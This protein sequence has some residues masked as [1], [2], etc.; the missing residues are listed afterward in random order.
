MPF[1]LM[2][3]LT[4]VFIQHLQINDKYLYHVMFHFLNAYYDALNKNGASQKGRCDKRSLQAARNSL[5]N[6]L[7]KLDKCL[8]DSPI[9]EALNFEI[10]LH[11]IFSQQGNEFHNKFKSNKEKYELCIAFTM[12]LIKSIDNIT[13]ASANNRML[14]P[15]MRRDGE[16]KRFLVRMLARY[17][18]TFDKNYEEAITH[19]ADNPPHG[20]VFGGAFAN[21]V[22]AVFQELPEQCPSG[23]IMKN[24]LDKVFKS[25]S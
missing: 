6:S 9:R 10:A 11:E 14:T 4:P 24:E 5:K 2:E 7:E 22:Q 23:E 17:Y 18:K 13:N 1:A 8:Y 21:F 25:K 15:Q 3:K 20:A 12:V 16:F 19:H